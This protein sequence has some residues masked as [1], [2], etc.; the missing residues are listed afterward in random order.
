MEKAYDIC[1]I[2]DCLMMTKLAIESIIIKVLSCY[3]S[4]VGLDNT[5]EDTF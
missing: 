4:Q 2:S 5:I 1:R 3:A